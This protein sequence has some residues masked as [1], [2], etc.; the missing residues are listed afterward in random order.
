[1]F[2]GTPPVLLHAPLS[3]HAERVSAPRDGRCLYRPQWHPT[4]DL[5]GT[6]GANSPDQEKTPEVF[7]HM[8]SNPGRKFPRE[9]DSGLD[10]YG[11]SLAPA[12]RFQRGKRYPGEK[13]TTPWE[14]CTAPV[15]SPNPMPQRN[16][17]SRVACGDRD[18]NFHTHPHRGGR[19]YLGAPI[20]SWPSDSSSIEKFFD[21]HFFFIAPSSCSNQQPWVS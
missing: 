15:A 11:H 17:V 18:R 6:K 2:T 3:A 5:A 7:H 16:G 14:F 4:D 12:E 10:I 19:H 13:V 9:M 1:M 20:P 8:H 21:L